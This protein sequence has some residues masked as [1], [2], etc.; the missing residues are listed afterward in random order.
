MSDVIDDETAWFPKSQIM[1]KKSSSKAAHRS[2][3]AEND[4]ED[5]G[6]VVFSLG[7]ADMGSLNRYLHGGRVLPLDRTTLCD[8][9]G[10]VDTS[11]ISDP[12]WTKIDGLVDAYKLVCTAV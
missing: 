7:N 10:I 4:D 12:I 11:L 2:T 1:G 9:V 5:D 8:K 6:D 3:T